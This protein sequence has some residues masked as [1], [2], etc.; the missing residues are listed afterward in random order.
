LGD[1]EKR[2]GPGGTGVKL[3]DFLHKKLADLSEYWY[4]R[5]VKR[6]HIESH[7]EYKATGTLSARLQYKG[8]KEFFDGQERRVR[9]TSKIKTKRT[10][11]TGTKRKSR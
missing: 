7:K 10:H 1:D 11:R 3:R 4:K 8:K 6:G 9:V 2:P 5:G